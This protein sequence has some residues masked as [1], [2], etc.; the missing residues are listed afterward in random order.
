[1]E[2]SFEDNREHSSHIATCKL[3]Q[4]ELHFAYARGTSSSVMLKM[5]TG[6][7]LIFVITPA[8]SKRKKIRKGKDKIV[9]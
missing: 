2:L 1:M 8:I 6:V 9:V 5:K 4:N 3:T 7:A